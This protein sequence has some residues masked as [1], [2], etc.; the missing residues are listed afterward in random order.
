MGA[1]TS[2]TTNGV[3]TTI[4]PS[5][6]NNYAVP[7]AITTG[8]ISN[9]M[10]WNAFLGLL[11]QTGANSDT[12][13]LG[14]DGSGRPNTL[15]LPPSSNTTPGATIYYNYT[16][17]SSPAALAQKTEAVSGTHGTRTTYDGLGRTIKVETGTFSGFVPN[18]SFN[19]PATSVVDTQY[20][21]CGCSPMGKLKQ[22][23][24]PQAPG[25]TVHWTI[26]N[27]D[28]RGRTTSVVSPDGAST[29]QYI[30][31][32]DAGDVN[33][34]KT[35]DP[36]GKWKKFVMNALGNLTQVIEPDPNSSGTLVTNYTYDLMNH[37]TIVSMPR[38]V[39]GSNVTQTRTWVYDPATQR[40]SSTTNPE[41][42]TVTYTYNADGTLSQKQDAIGQQLRYVY[43]SLK[44]VTQVQHW[45]L[46]GYDDTPEDITY[47]YDTPADTGFNNTN[48]RI[49]SATYQA[50]GIPIVE[51]YGYTGPGAIA[52][53]RMRIYK[54]GYS[55]PYADLVATLAYGTEGQL[56]S[57]TYPTTAFGGTLS[58]SYQYD[59][60]ARLNGMTDNNS[61]QIVWG[62]QYGP[63]N[64]L[65]Q[66]SASNFS[67]TRTYNARLQ[68]TSIV[69]QPSAFNYPYVN[70][71]YTYSATQ[72]NGKIQ[73]MTNNI[74]NGT[75]NYTYDVEPARDGHRWRV[76]DEFHV[77]WIW[78]PDGPES[79][80]RNCAN[81]ELIDLWANESH[82]HGRVLLR[83]QRESDA[84][85]AGIYLD[86]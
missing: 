57:I 29:T 46:G 25:A 35:I 50:N 64:E 17:Y 55:N 18:V 86:L 13:N 51:A 14:Y 16:N 77:R 36:A 47:T 75:V 27:Y 9:S 30:Y 81:Q 76:F 61:N 52:A 69:E 3:T 12:T 62:V 7:S 40:L 23:S 49:A 8:G 67:E 45:K 39:N 22:V 53:K 70:T 56:G 19:S 85:A 33:A 21:P 48:G 20:A 1:A 15:T 79:H 37:L 72:N 58:Y 65:L 11:S 80:R 2:S 83:Q 74:N 6:T 10:S 4:S 84:G 34:V 31:N 28:V 38:V 44:R 26:Y 82:H 32:P 66:M 42:G 54:P 68:V 59:S 78:E 43:D 24:Q 41:N 73:S 60:L 5:V 71:T 63:A